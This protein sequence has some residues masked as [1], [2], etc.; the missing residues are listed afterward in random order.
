MALKKIIEL[1]GD[2]FLSTPHGSIKTGKSKLAIAAY[3]KV[4]NVSGDKNNINATVTFTDD[5]VKF[6]KNYTFSASVADGASNFIKQTYEYLKTLPEF[7]NSE[8]C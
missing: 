8:D 6:N 5:S 1:E 4:Q 7:E 3:I 2:T